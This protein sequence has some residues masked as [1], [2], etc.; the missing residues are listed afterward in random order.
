[1]AYM[2]GE[3]YVYRASSDTHDDVII[4][5]TIYGDFDL[6]LELF[7]TLVVMRYAQL[8]KEKDV[9]M[10]EKQVAEQ[11]QGYFGCDALCEK[12]GMETAQERPP[13]R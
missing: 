13:A 9:K 11:Y 2:R 10:F 7:D 5:H 1:M 6:S 4:G 8:Q 3:N 12:Y